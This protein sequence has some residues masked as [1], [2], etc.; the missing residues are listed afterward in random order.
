MVEW[1]GAAVDRRQISVGDK[2]LSDFI[3]CGPR[4]KTAYQGAGGFAGYAV[5]PAAALC[6]IPERLNFDQAVNLLASY[7]TAYHCI[8]TRARRC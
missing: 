5:V 1:A 6:R 2:V 3:A 8:I 4:A 7:E